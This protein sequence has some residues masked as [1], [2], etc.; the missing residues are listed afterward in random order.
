MVGP[1]DS[2]PP[3]LR[4]ETHGRIFFNIICFKLFVF[5]FFSMSYNV[6]CIDTSFWIHEHRS[7]VFLNMFLV[8]K[9]F[10]I[11]VRHLSHSHIGRSGTCMQS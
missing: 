6:F 7:Q 11:V 9:D 2:K 10:E 5:Y 1:L 8:V 4:F 3:L